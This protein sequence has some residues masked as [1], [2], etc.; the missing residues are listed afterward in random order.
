MAVKDRGYLCFYFGVASTSTN[1][2]MMCSTK[3]GLIPPHGIAKSTLANVAHAYICILGWLPVV[4]LFAANL[5]IIPLR[6]R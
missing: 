4:A 1:R 3:I 2:H 6:N 5:H